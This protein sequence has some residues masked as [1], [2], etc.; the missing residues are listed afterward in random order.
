M[1]LLNYLTE[2]NYRS[3]YFVKNK[4]TPYGFINVWYNF[5][6]NCMIRQP[7]TIIWKV[8]LYFCSRKLGI[9]VQSILCIFFCI[10]IYIE[11]SYDS[12][13]THIGLVIFSRGRWHK[14]NILPR[15]KLSFQKNQKCLKLSYGCKKKRRMK[16]IVK[17]LT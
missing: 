8:L 14:F 10:I 12:F 17:K 15:R 5:S 11:K 6:K 4:N 9:T 13:L 2:T 1:T 7:A 3:N 16:T